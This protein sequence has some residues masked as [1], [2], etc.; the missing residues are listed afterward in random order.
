MNLVT[1]IILLVVAMLFFYQSLRVFRND[2][3][4]IR[5]KPQLPKLVKL[6]QML[7][8]ITGILLWFSAGLIAFITGITGITNH[9]ILRFQ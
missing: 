5:R 2:V 3:L 8:G 1:E 6:M 7:S 9:L 4:L